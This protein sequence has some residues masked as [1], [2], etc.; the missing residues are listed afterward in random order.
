[1]LTRPMATNCS[2]GAG[3]PWAEG[4]NP[5]T[6]QVRPPSPSGARR[7]R[8]QMPTGSWSRSRWSRPPAT[9]PSMASM[10]FRGW[11]VGRSRH[12][13]LQ[14]RTSPHQP[15]PAA[16]GLD[17]A[18]PVDITPE[19]EP[20]RRAKV[21]KSG[22]PTP[23]E[24]ESIS[25]AKWY[26]RKHHAERL[27]R[28]QEPPAHLGSKGQGRWRQGCPRGHASPTAACCSSTPAQRIGG[29]IRSGGTL[30]SR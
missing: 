6:V 21:A 27:A 15:A 25:R 24:L 11:L 8:S 17:T 4:Q 29:Q 7:S 26:R 30:L 3:F 13:R 23:W 9:C 12:P 1:M 16:P 2:W 10:C 19:A 20:I 18:G 5:G 28:G 22:E 14:A